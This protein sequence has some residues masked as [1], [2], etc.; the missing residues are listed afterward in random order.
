MNANLK[1]LLLMGEVSCIQN[2]WAFMQPTEP[3]LTHRFGPRPQRS[4]NPE[5][6]FHIQG[7]LDGQDP[8]RKVG[9]T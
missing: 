8:K 7:P 4:D 3:A 1:N 9:L 5:P 2:G 6:P